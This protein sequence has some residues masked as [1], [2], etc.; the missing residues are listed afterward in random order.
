MNKKNMVLRRNGVLL[1]ITLWMALIAGP[2]RA[3][4]GNPSGRHDAVVRILTGQFRL[5]A[6]RA[7]HIVEAVESAADK[8]HVPISLILAIIQTESGF[9]PRATSPA[10]AIGLMQVMPATHHDFAA[11]GAAPADLRDPAG[12]VY[13]GTSILRRYI[14]DADGDMQQA[15][16]RYSGGTHGYARRVYARWRYFSDFADPGAPPARDT[17][18]ALRIAPAGTQKPGAP[19]AEPIRAASQNET[20]D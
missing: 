11:R 12:N 8:L 3:D 1:C 10:G 4:D 5:N 19:E 6:Q 2:A 13:I 18:L 16:A 7:E 15:L 9:D 17:T 20:S 14:D